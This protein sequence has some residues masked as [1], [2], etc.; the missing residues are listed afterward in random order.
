MSVGY[1]TAAWSFLYGVLGLYWSLGGAGYPFGENGPGSQFSAFAGVRADTGA[2]VIAIVGLLGAGAAMTIVRTRAC[3]SVRSALL[4]FAWTT[5]ALLLLVV[6]DARALVAVAY[7]PAALVA[8]IIGRVPDDY[9]KAIPW[10]VINQFLCVAGGLLWASTAIA[11][12]PSSQAATWM[13]PAAAARWGRRLVSVA[14]IIPLVYAATRWTWA[15]GFSVGIDPRLLAAARAHGGTG[16]A[17]VLGLVATCGAALT[18]GLTQRW[19]EVFPR[20]VPLIG[21]R[22]VPVVLAVVPASIAAILVT[23]AGLMFWRRTL[24]GSGAF[25]VSR[26]NWAALVPELLWPV[27]GVTLGSAT[28]AYY[29]RRTAMPPPAAAD[30]LR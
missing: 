27:W 13:T 5:A 15:L 23:S 9:R 1:L 28:L 12:Q 6:P 29:V 11:Y 14:T 20:W 4:A 8:A 10:P 18:L 26:E 22:A 2:P 3:G 17:A 25:T 24:L 16:A 19:G 30:D 21:G 7:A